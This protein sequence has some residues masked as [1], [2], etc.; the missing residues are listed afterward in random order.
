MSFYIDRDKQFPMR[1]IK[2]SYD[3]EIE[4]IRNTPFMEPDESRDAYRM[5]LAAVATAGTA[6]ALHG[7]G[8]Q[9][10]QKKALDHMDNYLEGYYSGQKGAKMLSFGKEAGK[11][12]KGIA[13]SY[14]NPFDT[15]AYEATGLTQKG[16]NQLQVYQEELN[17]IYDDFNQ[18]T[19][20]TKN[21]IKIYNNKVK[22]VHKKINAKLINDS[23]NYSMFSEET[24]KGNIIEKYGKKTKQIE[25]LDYKNAK[26]KKSLGFSRPIAKILTDAQGID[27]DNTLFALKRKN[28]VTGDVLHSLQFDKRAAG[29]FAEMNK[30]GNKP[31][32]KQVTDFLDSREWKYTQ[33]NNKV[34]FHL[35]PKGKP[36][37]DWGGYNGIVEWDRT[38]KGKIKLHAN[39]MRDW[40]KFRVGDR[41][42]L[43]MVRPKEISIPQI[44]KEIK[45][46]PER[47]K[48]VVS[49]ERKK[50]YVPKP[51][52]LRDPRNLAI[53]A[54]QSELKSG[55][56]GARKGTK[57]PI[58]FMKK[59]LVSRLGLA[60]A[61]AALAALGYDYWKEG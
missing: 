29:L 5:A 12:A 58:S 52:K 59:F 31:T 56:Q 38:K 35:S 22:S 49:P 50:E 4:E 6:A 37:L 11:A 36:D 14:F 40:G 27:I 24:G 47:K 10:F 1:D 30:L 45:E 25:V 61:I 41:P 51:K 13:A 8:G 54:A 17:K 16:W 18:E 3:K 39:D 26:I 57:L 7:E 2:D 53:R 46:Q 43:N 21:K 34:F 48:T 55:Y 15:Y 44:I 23:V 42:V 60:G 32:T 33:H 28:V 9:Y 19:K 20:L